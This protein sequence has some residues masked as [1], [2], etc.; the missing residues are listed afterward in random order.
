MQKTIAAIFM[1]GLKCFFFQLH[2][3]SSS[4]SDFLATL[5]FLTLSSIKRENEQTKEWKRM[6][7]IRQQYIRP[8]SAQYQ[9]NVY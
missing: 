2:L 3:L 9:V 5:P 1:D 7:R 6:K 4:S 8:G